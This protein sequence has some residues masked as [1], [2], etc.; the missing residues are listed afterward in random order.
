V[1][2]SEHHNTFLT[3]QNLNILPSFA[4][5][6]VDIIVSDDSDGA[7]D[8]SRKPNDIL[9]KAKI[10]FYI[11]DSPATN[12]LHMFNLRLSSSLYIPTQLYYGKTGLPF[13]TPLIN[14]LQLVNENTKSITQNGG[15]R[16]NTTLYLFAETF[17][18][19]PGQNT[20]IRPS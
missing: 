16:D 12:V 5:Y 3:A 15:S 11:I 9:P 18:Q 17:I 4:C 19:I 6:D 14:Q 20:M 2:T 8:N 1:E 13:V 10:I 7:A